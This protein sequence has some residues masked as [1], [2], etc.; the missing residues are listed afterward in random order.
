MILEPLVLDSS[1]EESILRVCQINI[2]LA[3]ALCRMP[4]NDDTIKTFMEKCPSPLTS[5]D[6]EASQADLRKFY[7]KTLKG[8]V[9]VMME[10]KP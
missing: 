5:F 7:L 1:S 6:G 10:A 2:G 9:S 4:H 8:I 3:M